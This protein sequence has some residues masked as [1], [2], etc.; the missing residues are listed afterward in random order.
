MQISNRP[1]LWLATGLV[2]GALCSVSAAQAQV[3]VSDLVT[4]NGALYHNNYTVTNSSSTDVLLIDITA[5]ADP[6]AVQNP[7]APAGYGISFDP[8]FGLVT[9]LEDTDP[10]NN[11]QFFGSTPVSGFQYDSPFAPTGA[12]FTAY[13]VDANGNLIVLRSSAVT[14]EPGMLSVCTASVLTGGLLL[15]RRRLARR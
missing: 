15:R 3:T 13:A 5:P 1:A 12:I 10:L 11:P 2:T 7:A 6:S 9:L 14:P 8:G 4:P